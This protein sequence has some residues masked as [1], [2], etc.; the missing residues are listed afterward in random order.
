M[1]APDNTTETATAAPLVSPRAQVSLLTLSILGLAVWLA[2]NTVDFFVFESSHRWILLALTASFALSERISFHIEARNE[3]VSHTP[4]DIA[5]A[6]G[7]LFLSPFELVIAR[8]IGAG[9]GLMMWRRGPVFKT[10]FN[11]AHFTLET[12]FAVWLF[13]TLAGPPHVPTLSSAMLLLISILAALV[14]GGLLVAT[15]ISRFE[16]GLAGKLIREVRNSPVFYLPGAVIGVSVAIPMR[17]DT[18]LGLMAVGPAPVLWY[19]IRAHGALLHRYTDLT[20]VHEFSREVGNVADPEDIARKAVAQIAENLRSGSVGLRIWDA[21]GRPVDVVHGSRGALEHLPADIADPAWAAMFAD[22]MARDYEVVG[23]A[24]LDGV[25]PDTINLLLAPLVDERGPIGALALGDRMGVTAAFDEDDRTRLSSIAQ[26]LA[27]AIR[28]GQFHSQIQ[29]EAT[30]DRLTGLP[31]RGYFEAWIDQSLSVE[32]TRGAVLLIDLDRFKEINDTF[33]HHTGDD[34]L[35]AVAGR[36]RSNVREVD[37]AARFGGDEF[38]VFVPEADQHE[39]EALAQSIS[40]ALEQPF[41]LQSATV[42]IA[43]SVGIA[44]APEHGSD[45][46]VLLRRGDI[47]MYDAKRRHARSMVYADSLEEIDSV[48]LALLADLRVALENNELTV[49]YQPK[50]D[51]RSDT[52]VAA[53]ALVRWTHPEHGFVSPEVFVGLAEQAGL[54]EELTRQVLRLS[55]EA[56]N[57]WRERGLRLSIAVNVSAQSLLDEQLEGLVA[58]EL[59]RSGVDPEL[60]TL[61]ITESTMMGDPART[62]RILR[63]LDT[64]GVQLSVDDFGTGFSS[65]V[66]LRHLP[67]SELKIDR[68]FVT[69]MLRERHDEVIVQS[70]VDLAHNLGLRVVAEGVEDDL[71]LEHLTAIGCDVA[72]GFG[73]SRPLPFDEFTSWAVARRQPPS[74]PMPTPTPAAQPHPQGSA[75]RA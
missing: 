3:A 56:V 39:A 1:S 75:N 23:D 64:F 51:L 48:R 43:A 22:G 11:M 36:I 15:A 20:S 73:I 18:W 41:P 52:V 62:H 65:L 4:S 16:G 68:S 42:A 58:A 70:T 61:E 31:N 24:E 35:K 57:G 6:I 63:S 72:Q 8:F 55:L 10:T 54:I 9:V 46:Q 69:D 7:L 27:V 19:L 29:H 13:R 32:T 25:E 49:H 67:V 53:E 14:V 74:A 12:V 38:A 37:V 59:A 66:N 21:A 45:A 26:Q 30:H 17:I 71:V 44:V 40:A 33:G 60:L 5:L 34:L 2:T 47:A 28:K 50:L